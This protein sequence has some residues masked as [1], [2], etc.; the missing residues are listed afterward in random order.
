MA[1]QKQIDANKRNAEKSTGPRTQQ[2][3]ARSRMNALRHG[4]SSAAPD[5]STLNDGLVSYETI[6]A[7]HDRLVQ[8]YSERV[9]ILSAIDENLK[10]P[11]FSEVYIAVQRLAALERYSRRSYSEIKKYARLAHK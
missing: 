1:T 4:L 11:G 7:V 6:A 5:A 9:K 3:K 10:Q 2:G 8:F